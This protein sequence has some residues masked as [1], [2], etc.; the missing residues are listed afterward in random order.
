MYRSYM[1]KPEEME[2]KWFVV[3]AEGKTLGRLASQVASILRG[4]HKPIFTPHVDCGDH[5]IVINAEKIV[6]TGNKLR[7]KIYYRHT[8]YPGGLRAVP[9]GK[10]LETQ[11]E[12]AVER[13]IKGMIPHTRLGHRIGMKLKVYK[14]PE[15]PHAAQK[16]EPLDIKA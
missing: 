14:G 8:M 13:A 3:D 9:Y 11:P 5:V 2:R 16:P 4:K 10:L 7:D 6:L 12:R 1:A 15:H